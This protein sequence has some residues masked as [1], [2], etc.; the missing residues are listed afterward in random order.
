[1]GDVQTRPGSLRYVSSE[2]ERIVEEL[3]L[4]E[5]DSRM[6]HQI[7]KQTIES[8]YEQPSFDVIVP[9]VVYLA[10]RVVGPEL[11]LRDIADVAR[12]DL[13]HIRTVAKNI[14]NELELPI[15]LQTAENLLIN[16]LEAL[17]IEEFETDF[18]RLIRSVDDSYKGS[19]SPAS[20]AAG[21]AYVGVIMFDLDYPKQKDIAEEFGV[22]VVTVRNRYPEV[23]ERSSISPPREE[24]RFDSFEEAFDVLGN[25]LD[26]PEEVRKRAEARVTLAQPEF[27]GGVSKAGVVLGAIAATAAQ[28]HG[29]T[30][31]T[32]TAEL[33]GYAAVTEHTIQKHRDFLQDQ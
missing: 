29:P 32:D 17:G 18:K 11:T 31:L 27:G 5:Q 33:A 19:K 30:R 26:V 13:H 25:D 9:A 3:N 4:G 23:I 7:F 20:V 2:I 6:A 22:T 12:R 10:D 14:N 21:A 1:M 15:R 16:R 8:E 24:R 28:A